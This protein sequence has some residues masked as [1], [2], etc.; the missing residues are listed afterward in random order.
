MLAQD[1]FF[2]W[3]RT[4]IMRSPFDVLDGNGLNVMGNRPGSC[5]CAK[6]PQYQ[7]EDR[8]RFNSLTYTY[9]AGGFDKLVR[10]VLAHDDERVFP[11]RDWLGFARSDRP[12]Q[13]RSS[14]VVCSL[15]MFAHAACWDGILDRVPG[16]VADRKRDP[17]EL[18]VC[19]L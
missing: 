8:W 17:C 6:W 14:N 3:V 13:S 2:E 9:K 4:C 16:Q 5:V 15:Q 11:A 12:R 18:H 19:Q 10:A 7:G 1:I